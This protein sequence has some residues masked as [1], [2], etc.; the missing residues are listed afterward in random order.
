MTEME[1]IVLL[2]WPVGMAVGYFCMGLFHRNCQDEECALFALPVFWPALILLG[3]LILPFLVVYGA[4]K[5][6][7]KCIAR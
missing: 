5:R 7:G 4:G 3:A 1:W 2:I 6:A